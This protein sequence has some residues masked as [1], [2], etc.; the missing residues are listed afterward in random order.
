[1]QFVLNDFIRRMFDVMRD[2]APAWQ[3]F[4]SDP[5]KR[6][7]TKCQLT[8]TDRP[9]LNKVDIVEFEIRECSLD[10]LL[11]GDRVRDGACW[12]SK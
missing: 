10:G 7:S 11:N 4:A 2:C 8:L 9:R 1:M 5:C 3:R 6:S 12:R